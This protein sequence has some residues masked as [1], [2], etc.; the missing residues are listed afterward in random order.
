MTVL[1]HRTLSAALA[2]MLAGGALLGALA[3]APAAAADPWRDK[4]FWIKD[5]GVANVFWYPTTSSRYDG[6]PSSL[7]LQKGSTI[8]FFVGRRGLTGGDKYVCFI[9]YI[10]HATVG[11]FFMYKMSLNA[12]CVFEF[13]KFLIFTSTSDKNKC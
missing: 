4:E 7:C 9:I 13:N 3:T 12:M 10:V 2:S 8:L 6:K 5:S 1:R 11:S